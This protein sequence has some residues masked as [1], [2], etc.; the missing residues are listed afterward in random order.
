MNEYSYPLYSFKVAE[1][2]KEKLQIELQP[3]RNPLLCG[4]LYKDPDDVMSIMAI[5]FLKSKLSQNFETSYIKA[6]AHH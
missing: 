2:Y 5:N 1:A 6:K 4:L 3:F